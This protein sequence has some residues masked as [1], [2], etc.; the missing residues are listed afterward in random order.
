MFVRDSLLTS[1]VQLAGL[2][3]VYIRVVIVRM[4]Q[5]IHI[6]IHSV[7]LLSTW[8]QSTS[9]C[10]RSIEAIHLHISS[11]FFQIFRLFMFIDQSIDW[12]IFGFFQHFLINYSFNWS[13]PFFNCFLIINHWFDWLLC[14]DPIA[15][16]HHNGSTWDY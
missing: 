8:Y 1:L 3:L 7:F 10:S 15:S 2:L 13:I 5:S 4:I 9:S 12:L 14:F 16:A 6:S 11:D